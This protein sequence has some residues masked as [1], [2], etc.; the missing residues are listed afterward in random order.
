MMLSWCLFSLDKHTAA[1]LMIRRIG[2]GKYEV[3]GR[4]VT[5]C[6]PGGIDAK[7]LCILE[8]DIGKASEMPAAAYLSQAAHVAASLRG[9]GK[10]LGAVG[11][12]PQEKRLTFHESSNAESTKK[13]DDPSSQIERVS[14]MRLACEQ[15]KLREQYAAWELAQNRPHSWTLARSFEM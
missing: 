13:I 6:C 12:L 3:D 1:S 11:Q 5:L 9:C 15:A 4:R 14:S 2:K 7:E 10:G 8:D